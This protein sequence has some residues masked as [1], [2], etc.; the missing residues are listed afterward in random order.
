[1]T[2]NIF[3]LEDQTSC[4][5]RLDRL[6]Q[7]VMPEYETITARDLQSAQ[8]TDT[9]DCVM[10]FI[11]LG[12]PDGKSFDYITWHLAQHPHIP[13]II[14]TFYDD[15]ESI[16]R[17]MSLGVMGYLLKSDSDELLTNALRG[18]LMG[19]VPISPYIAKQLMS[20]LSKSQLL[21]EPDALNA[22]TLDSL[23]ERELDVLKLISQGL[24]TKQ[25]AHKLS[26]SEHSVNDVIKRIYKKCHI[27]NRVEAQQFAVKHHLI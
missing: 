20:K 22:T 9:S 6:I 2:K 25:V 14:T 10:G 1:M 4:L 7:S 19:Q 15:N 17:A 18:I 24:M 13:L 16:F 8:K 26:L 21:F 23:S 11:D 3:I 12:L 5:T 27:R